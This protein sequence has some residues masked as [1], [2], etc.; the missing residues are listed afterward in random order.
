[1]REHPGQFFVALGL[2][3]QGLGE[4]ASNVSLMPADN[5]NV[6]SKL[7]T[8]PILSR[9]V[10]SAWGIDL[11]SYALKAV[12]LVKDASGNFQVDD[13]H[14]ILLPKPLAH[15][16]AE[17][18]RPAILA[19]ALSDLAGRVD[20]KG[21][22]IAAGLSG[23][24][25][26]G[27]FFDL[28]P[29]PP[30]KVASAVEYEARHQIPIDLAELCWDWTELGESDPKQAGKNPQPIMVV[31]ARQS[32]VEGRMALFAS[33]GIRLDA[34]QSDC[35]ALHNALRFELEGEQSNGTG[36]IAV[37]DVGA[38]ETNFVV[39]SPRS[40]WFRSL[41]LAGH[42]F[43]TA[44]LQQFQLTFERAEDL[45]RHPAK[46]RRYYQF[47]ET[48]QPLWVQFADEIDRS[49][50]SFRRHSPAVNVGRLFAVGG[51]MNL[52][53]LLGHCAKTNAT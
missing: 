48:L 14:Y 8:L 1:M 49:L 28:P 22:P 23:H 18:Q 24:Q 3:L 21:S 19:A 52:H 39:S 46:A 42:S 17:G 34:L 9:R 50:C 43:T 45:K 53:G 13:A 30:K 31:A 26:L 6:L 47:R 37:V 27:R 16:D 15:P 12:K 2:A 51:G 7:A 35:V 20:L 4:A 10:T 29:L 5:R 36:P 38:D 11:G 44:L 41:G 25:V 40:I 33:A 32:H